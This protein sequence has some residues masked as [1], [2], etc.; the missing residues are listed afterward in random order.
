MEVFAT[1]DGQHAQFADRLDNGGNCTRLP[2]RVFGER[3]LQQGWPGPVAGAENASG[4]ERPYAPVDGVE[5]AWQRHQHP[6]ALQKTE[7]GGFGVRFAGAGKFCQRH[8]ELH[9]CR[10]ERRICVL[11]LHSVGS[12]EVLPALAKTLNKGF[13]LRD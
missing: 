6:C 11:A 1:G 3:R 7:T 2:Q 4:F 8:V 5:A 10:L 12:L 9:Q 13:R